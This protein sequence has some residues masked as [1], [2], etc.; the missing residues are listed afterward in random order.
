MSESRVRL[1][2]FIECAGR[3]KLRLF[4]QERCSRNGAMRL[5]ELRCRR[6]ERFGIRRLSA[7]RHL[8]RS[9]ASVS[10]CRRD[11]VI[12]RFWRPEIG[13]SAR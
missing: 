2:G 3:T 5:R 10:A 4:G 13:W 7:V 12:R 11:G 8:V 9:A 6:R 1:R